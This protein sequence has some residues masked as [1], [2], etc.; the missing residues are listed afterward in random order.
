MSEGYLNKGTLTCAK[1]RWTPCCS[2]GR[3][4]ENGYR[5]SSSC[6]R[7]MI[8]ANSESGVPNLREGVRV[9]FRRLPTGARRAAGLA[10][11][12]V[13]YEVGWSTAL[14]SSG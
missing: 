2:C 14:S 13:D 11:T 1:G 12:K 8:D 5:K 9:A 10:I 4:D 3:S 6:K 7:A